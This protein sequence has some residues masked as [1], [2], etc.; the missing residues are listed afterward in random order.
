[1]ALPHARHGLREARRLQRLDQIVEGVGLERLD[2]EF[3]VRSHEDHERHSVDHV[4]ADHAEAVQV[5]HLHVQE[6]EVGTQELER[7]QGFAARA[8]F[9]DHDDIGVLAEHLPDAA[10]GQR[11]IVDDQ[12]P[13]V[14][15]REVPSLAVP[16][17]RGAGPWRPHRPSCRARG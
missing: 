11:L 6:D 5:R 3:V 17:D 10:P 9:P 8:T 14:R 4:R 13:E 7:V 2:G 16:C 12:H 1:M 15:H